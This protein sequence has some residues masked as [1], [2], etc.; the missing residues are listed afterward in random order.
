MAKT[1]IQGGVTPS[2]NAIF[3][4]FLYLDQHDVLIGYG[5]ENAAGHTAKKGKMLSQQRFDT[6]EEAEAERAKWREKLPFLSASRELT[7]SVLH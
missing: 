2:S 3:K 7:A 6:K 1:S 4:Y 5:T